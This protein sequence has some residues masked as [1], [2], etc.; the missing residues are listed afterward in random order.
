MQPHRRQPTRL[1]HPWDSPGKNTGVGCLSFSNAWKWKVRVKS[2]SHVRLL[3]TPWTAAHQAPPS[4]GFS[5]QEYWSGLPLPPPYWRCIATNLFTI[6]F[7]F[8]NL[9]SFWIYLLIFSHQIVFSNTKY[10]CLICM[11]SLVLFMNLSAS[12]TSYTMAPVFLWSFS[13]SHVFWLRVSLLLL[14]HLFPCAFFLSVLH[15]SVSL[16]FPVSFS[17]LLS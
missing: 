5:R 7:F 17:D 11:N 9:L 16:M 8:V 3:A 10:L 14:S 6:C 2:L 1:P 4:M 13:F 12:C 15:H